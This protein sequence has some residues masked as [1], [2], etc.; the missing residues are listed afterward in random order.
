MTG[1]DSL[2]DGRFYT[3]EEIAETINTSVS[4]VRL[5]CRKHPEFCTRFGKARTAKMVLTKAQ[6]TALFNHLANPPKPDP[7]DPDYDPFV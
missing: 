6:A 1:L 2:V 4:R 7:R 3:P 5:T